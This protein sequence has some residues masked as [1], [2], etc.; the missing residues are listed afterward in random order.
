VLAF[1]ADARLMGAFANSPGATAALAAV[2]T[3]VVAINLAGAWS[4]SR[5][6]LEDAPGWAWGLAGAGVA[7]YVGF[8]AALAAAMWRG[9]PDG[10]D[11]GGGG[12][13][14]GGAS[15]SGSGGRGALAEPLLP[16]APEDGG[17]GAEPV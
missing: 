5:E 11:D 3:G 15:G 12:G 8:L 10:C 4:F 9:P 2:S 17:P 1:N 13:S 7:A 16:A 14:G 6:H